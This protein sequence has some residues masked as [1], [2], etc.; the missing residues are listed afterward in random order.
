MDKTLLEKYLDNKC[1]PRELDIVL[2]WLREPYNNEEGKKLSCQIISEYKENDIQMADYDAMLNSIHH[3]INMIQAERLLEHVGYELPK[4][5]RR[6]NIFRFFRYAAAILLVPVLAL[7]LMFAMKYYS[8]KGEQISVAQAYNQVFSSVDAITMVSLPDGST[9]WLNHSSSLRYPAVF[10]GKSREVELS[11][12]GYFEVFSNPETP[13][14]VHAAD[15]QIHALGTSFNV[16]AYPNE[17]KVETSLINGTVELRKPSPDG[18]VKTLIRMNPNDYSIYNRESSE[19]RTMS[20]ADDRYFAWKEGKLIFNSEPMEEVVK[21]LSRW[22]NV[23][24]RIKDKDLLDLKL[25]AT[26]VNET[27]PQVME[28]LE[29]IYPIQYTISDRKP[30]E[31]GSFT[32]KEVFIYQK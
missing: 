19:I 10:T 23:E 28:L 2:S 1:N 22:F 14:I 29:M 27:L 4:Y 25:K 7:G 26:F 16:M 12:E 30:N 13:F 6:Q 18:K 11:G 31:D 5:N 20:I 21:K 17:N 15:I 24:F 9:V 8:V 32:R 3:K